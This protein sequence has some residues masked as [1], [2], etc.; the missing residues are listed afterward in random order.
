MPFRSF[1]PPSESYVA[2]PRDFG[3]P[4]KNA[5]EAENCGDGGSQPIPRCFSLQA[6]TATAEPY[7]RPPRET[8]MLAP[9]PADAAKQ[10]HRTL[11]DFMAHIRV[12]LRACADAYAAARTYEELRHLSDAELNRRGLSRATLAS[13]LMRDREQQREL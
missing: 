10:T 12:W 3:A 6:I 2:T 8:T 11:A 7:A 9:T 1:S 4:G 13:D 5:Q